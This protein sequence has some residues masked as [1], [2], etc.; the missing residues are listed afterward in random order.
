MKPLCVPLGPVSARIPNYVC[1][2][3]FLRH[4]DVTHYDPVS[5]L[6]KSGKLAAGF[7]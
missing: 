3:L 7:F 6:H 1:P 4:S 2:A 5:R